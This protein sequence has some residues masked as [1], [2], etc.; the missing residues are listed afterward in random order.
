M[1]KLRLFLLIV[2]IIVGVTGC[3]SNS[4]SVAKIEVTEKFIFTKV[5]LNLSQFVETEI[6]YHTK[7]ELETI[8][9]DKIIKL[10]KDNDL[11]SNDSKMNTIMINANYIRRFV[12]D[13]MPISSDSLA[14]P[15]YSYTIEVFRGS[16]SLVLI[17][18]EDL[19]YK[20]GFVMNLQIIAAT[21]RDKK[22]EL[23]FIEAL[24]H[25]IFRD[26]KNLN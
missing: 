5:N 3:G 12:G 18:K 20:G 16:E 19:V 15:N 17:K 10:F 4:P 1:K 23:D 13:K 26:I 25:T 6:I 14:Y 7:E 9:N 22:Y 24:A 8:L 21:L 11:L 2:A